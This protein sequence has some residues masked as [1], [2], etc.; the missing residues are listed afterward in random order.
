MGAEELDGMHAALATALPLLLAVPLLAAGLAVLVRSTTARRAV[1]LATA[2]LVLAYAAALLWATADGTVL[3]EQVS[4]WPAGV[5]ISFAADTF[6]A[7]MVAVAALL[8]LVGSWYAVRAGDDRD[9]YFVPLV[10]VMSGGAYGAFATADLFNLFV[11]VEVALIPSYVLLTRSGRPGAVAAGRVYLT[12]NLLVSTVLLAGIAL[13]YGVT[14]TVNLGQLAGAAAGSTAAEVATGVVLVALAGKAALV[15]VHSWLPRSYPYAST[16]VS[17]ILSGLLTKIGVYGLFRVYSVVLDGDPRWAVV[18]QVVLVATMTVGVLGALGETSVRG[19]L[20]FHMVSQVGYILLGLG[21]FGVAGIAAGVFYLVHHII[22]KAAL[23]L[24]VGAVEETRG[25]GA[26]SRLGGVARTEPLLAL[27]FLAAA[28]SL[29]GIPPFSGFVAKYAL[30]RGA[31]EE[32]ALVAAGAALVVSL[33][34]LLSML[35][36][37]N[38]VFWGEDPDRGHRQRSDTGQ[39]SPSPATGGSGDGTSPT[40]HPAG[41]ATREDAS[42]QPHPR[43]PL[44]L[45]LP[46]VVLAACSLAIGVGAQGLLSLST[47]AAENLVDTAR[48][49]TAVTGETPDPT[50]TAP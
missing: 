37:W 19:V 1:G 32:G 22:V 25:T 34:T 18:A 7:L 40:T 21:F 17:A 12:I 48:Y 33:L 20:T 2:G 6:S 47:T 10:L 49:V 39:G 15:P 16:A 23:F 42:P 27:A 43:I 11:M 3:A 14:G 35:K 50:E 28:L 8:V 24:V 36:L 26:L 31:V 13:L 41:T 29:T 44:G 9:P 30:I 4:G 46:G 5:S 38:G 45:V